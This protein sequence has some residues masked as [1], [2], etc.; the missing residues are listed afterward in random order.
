MPASSSSKNS[1]RSDGRKD[2]GKG[3]HLAWWPVPVIVIALSG[4]SAAAVGFVYSRGY[5]LYFGDAMA[6]LNIARRMLDS[7]TPGWEQVGTVWLPLPHVL[8]LPLVRSEWLWRTGLAGS[9]VSGACFVLAGAFFFMAVRRA[10]SST[11]A[12]A[13]ACLALALNPNLLY[14]QA[15]PMTEAVF[16]ACIA[17]L[18]YFTVLFRDTQ[19]LWAAAAA[20]VFACAGTLTRY[21]GWFLLPF[22]AGYFLIAA[23]RRRFMAAAIFSAL[24]G[25]GPLLWLA[26][27]WWYWGNALE[28]YNGPWSAKA[29]NERA[30]QAGMAPYPGDHDWI[31]AYQYLREAVRLT[32]GTVLGLAGLAGFVAALYKRVF[33]PVLLLALVPLFYVWSIHSGS[34][35]VYVP[36]LWPNTYYNIR[37]AI[38]AL[39]LL[40]LGV[41]A[42]T[43][44]APVRARGAVAAAIVFAA[45]LPWLAFPRPDSWICWKE[46]EVNSD[47]RR[48]WTRAAAKYLSAR[49]GRGDGVFLSFGDLAG[50][51][52]EAGIPLAA[53]LHEGNRPQW[54]AAVLRPDLFLRERW[55]IATSDPGDQVAAALSRTVKSGPRYDLVESIAIKGAPVIHIYRRS[56][57]RPV[58]EG[59]RRQE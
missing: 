48:A 20:G 13:A 27:N 45:I 12:G 44:L 55:A 11:A 8:M 42:L 25:I 23:R 24:A 35:P 9:I 5:T 43:A 50:I 51:F 22:T 30:L 58:Y 14:L 6:H 41:A 10:F 26:H 19:S 17:G 4:L 37:Y 3:A 36:H 53:A 31:K 38:G 7:R 39:P 16:L 40:A 46:S 47:G 59:A 57:E 2:A 52:V 32:G 18:L 15:V 1:R 33:W 34:T 21:E 56:D 49:Y 29:I 54:E 28:F